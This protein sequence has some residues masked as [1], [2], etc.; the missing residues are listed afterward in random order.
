MGK[1]AGIWKKIK[2]VGKTIGKGL[3]KAATW[4]NDNIYKPGKDLFHPV[5]DMIDDTGTLNKF[6][7]GISKVID[8]GAQKLGY[9]S[10]D[11]F[12]QLTETVSDVIMDT[13]RTGKDKKYKDPFETAI[14]INEK[15]NDT[16]NDYNTY[17]RIKNGQSRQFVYDYSDDYSDSSDDDY[18]DSEYYLDENQRTVADMI[19]RRRNQK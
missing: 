17:R 9:N 6:A 14:H 4:V 11:S 13:Q 15:I 10:D 12:G 18:S 3:G 8:Y 7:D 16:I 19:R 1:A 2:Q 5:F